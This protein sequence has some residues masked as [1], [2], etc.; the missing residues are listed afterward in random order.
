MALHD[1]QQG[2]TPSIKKK[3]G[4]TPV[5]YGIWRACA[6]R[7][8]HV[9]KVNSRVYYFPKGHAEQASSPVN[10]STMA[11][12]K[13]A[14]QCRV[15]KVSY[16]ADPKTEEVL[17]KYKLEPWK[18][19]DEN[20][21]AVEGSGKSGVD[22]V[23]E[24]PGFVSFNKILTPSDA[25]N[26][27]GFSVPRQCAVRIFPKLNFALETPLQ[28]LL[29]S[30]VKGTQWMFRH[31]YRG[32]P[33]RHLLTTGWS[34]FV[35]A[36]NI[37]AGDTVVF[38]RNIQT[39]ELAVGIRRNFM[40]TPKL[41]TTVPDNANAQKG[42]SRENRGRV[43]PK[44]VAKAAKRAENGMP[45]EAVYYPRPGLAEFVVAADKVEE[46]CD[47]YWTTGT[48]VKMAL[49][50]YDGLKKTWHHGS[51]A[52][53][54]PID[55]CSSDI[56]WRMLE[57]SWDDESKGLQKK[58]KMRKVNP[59]QLEFSGPT[60]PIHAPCNP[61]KKYKY[62]HTD[63]EGV[64]PLSSMGMP[65]TMAA[66]LNSSYFSIQGTRHMLSCVLPFNPPTPNSIEGMK[67]VTNWLTMMTS[68]PLA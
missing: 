14:I 11:V 29:I 39:K 12:S 54:V 7:L 26:G 55:L 60:P 50:T 17:V 42:F 2:Y 62:G 37:I 56:E 10:F 20:D 18:L 44:A 27:G 5:G 59:W 6:G 64:T 23:E 65:S 52:S 68:C 28:N 63:S 36:K 22:T 51:I 34:K 48:R 19:D 25:N 49:E 30:D 58:Q 15:T 24:N 21:V 45:F 40:D 53:V 31:I 8:I 67:A 4:Y 41:I 1:Y 16:L 32:T 35:N 9:P 43:S 57:V 13:K 61:L 47:W 33:R 46:A 3:Q 38:I 66:Q